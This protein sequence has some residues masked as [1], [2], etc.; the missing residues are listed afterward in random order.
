MGYLPMRGSEEGLIFYNGAV[1]LASK[2]ERVAGMEVSAKG[3]ILQM[4]NG[5]LTYTES[6]CTNENG[7]ALLD[8]LSERGVDTLDFREEM[9]SDG[10][11]WYASYYIAD[12]HW[13]TETGLWAAGKLAEKLN[14]EAGM[15]FDL[16]MFQKQNYRFEIFEKCFLGG[17]GRSVTLVNAQ[18]EDY[19]RIL[20]AFETNF[21][22]QIPTRS[23]DLVGGYDRV[24]FDEEQLERIFHTQTMII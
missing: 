4:K 1:E 10:M 13:K 7:T 2:L 18:L 9:Q 16:S 8:A 14:E 3:D 5:Y 6:E 22:L 21:S 23:V 12:H 17:Q 15:N 20:P 19:T 24:L 11:D